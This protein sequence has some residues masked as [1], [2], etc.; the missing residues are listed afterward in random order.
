MIYNQCLNPKSLLVESKND[1]K[2]YGLTVG[3][4]TCPVCKMR[5]SR[6]WSLRLKME[7][8]GYNKD[9]ICFSTLTYDDSHVPVKDGLTTLYPRDMKNFMKRL[10]RRIHYPIRFFGVGEYGSRT[11]R[12][13]M[14]LLVFGLKKKDWHFIDDAWRRGF[15]CNKSFYNETC[16]YVAQYIQKKLFGKDVYGSQVPPFLRCSQS[17]SIGEDYFWKNVDTICQQGFIMADGYKHT[18]PRT[19]MR[20]AIDAGYLPE[21]DL[22][23]IQLISNVEVVDFLDHLAAQGVTNEDYYKNFKSLKLRSFDNSNRKRNYNE[24]V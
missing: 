18:I 23:E 22:D 24:V 12:P 16:G 5:R 10:R 6:E 20:K 13:H 4:G 3:C 19:F 8:A 14:H 11:F 17:P 21:T 2:E 9:E 15:V 7:A 1:G